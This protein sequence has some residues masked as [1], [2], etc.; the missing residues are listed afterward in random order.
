MTNKAPGTLKAAQLIIMIEV[1]F[2]LVG[3]AVA[4]AG[5]FFAF[6]WGH[7]PALIYAVA[8]TALL[9]WLSGRWSSRRTYVRWAIVAVHLLVIG[10]AVLDLVIFSTVT[11]QAMFGR[12]ILAWAVIVLLLLPS[13][14]R[15][16][17]EPSG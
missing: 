16:F 14:G 15:W 2:G 13:A 12:N 6:D 10:A 7:L 1:A 8:S 4:V 5:F 3:L 17:N 11:W 9:G